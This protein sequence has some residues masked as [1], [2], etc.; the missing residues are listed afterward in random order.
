MFRTRAPC[1][2][3]S[4]SSVA[5]RKGCAPAGARDS[6]TITQSRSVTATEKCVPSSAGIVKSSVFAPRPAWPVLGFSAFLAYEVLIGYSTHG[7]WQEKTW[8]LWAEF[9]P[10]YTVLALGVY[11]RRLNRT[12][13]PERTDRAGV[14][15]SP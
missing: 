15:F 3:A 8:V 12:P 13:R 4:V 7:I 10:F 5:I 6:G 11:R 14:S 2:K 9:V 1:S